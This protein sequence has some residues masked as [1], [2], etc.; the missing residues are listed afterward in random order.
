MAGKHAVIFR[1]EGGRELIADTLI[2]RGTRV[3]YAEVYRRRAPSEG[4]AVFSRLAREG[5]VDVVIVSSNEGLDNL[6]AMAGSERTRLLR[7]RLVVISERTA[8]HARDLGFELTPCVATESS[9]AGLVDAL[10][11]C[12]AP[13]GAGRP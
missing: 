7:T 13:A 8:A 3:E 1:G 11:A 4:A 10:R 5:W 2:G 9:D 6:L 12:Y